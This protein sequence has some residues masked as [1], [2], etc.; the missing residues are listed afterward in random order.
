MAKKKTEKI[1]L[2]TTP[3]STEATPVSSSP[4]VVV[5]QT[6]Q[7][8]IEW[9]DV[10]HATVESLK[11]ESAS[12]NSKKRDDFLSKLLERTIEQSSVARTY[13]VLILHDDGTMLRS[14]IDKIYSAINAF[15]EKKRILLVLYSLGGDIG[16]G[17]LIGKLCKE[18]SAGSF[19]VVVPRRAKSAATLL[20]CAAD[21]LHLGSLSELGPIDP[22]IAS[23]PALGLK[24]SVEH[25][26]TLV[27]QYTG[28]A[29]MFAKY[30]SYVLKPIDLGYYERVAESA[31]QYAERLLKNHTVPLSSPQ[32]IASTLV[33]D[34][35]DHGFV[36]DKTEA[37]EIFGAN[38]VKFNT[39]EYKLGN[40][41]YSGLSMLGTVAGWMDH[42]FYFI[43]SAHSNPVFYKRNRA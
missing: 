40:D 13:N 35:K 21:E 34:Y 9:S 3:I 16:S 14:D 32:K 31:M 36:I 18:Y 30:L 5:S 7:E 23:M 6:P 42:A 1:K 37:L 17:Y 38:V 15:K 27:Q 24:S 19:T 41:L 10:W 33:Y 20:C 39:P 4:S 28:T 43:G 8:T 11:A 12:E 29:E 2:P 25:I 26:A 22:Q